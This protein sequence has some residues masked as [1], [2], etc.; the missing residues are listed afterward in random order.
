MLLP[1][2]S[3]PATRGYCRGGAASAT[4]AANT[5]S[6]D[7]TFRIVRKEVVCSSSAVTLFEP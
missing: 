1:S 7:P 4:H 5:S 3:L 2:A 6:R